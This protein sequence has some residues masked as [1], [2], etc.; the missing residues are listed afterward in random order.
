MA[1]LEAG[2]LASLVFHF[3]SSERF[4]GIVNIFGDNHS[5][6]TPF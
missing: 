6:S 3:Q 5:I 1:S 2:Q 4:L